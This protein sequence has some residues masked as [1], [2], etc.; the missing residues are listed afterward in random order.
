MFAYNIIYPSIS[1]KKINTVAFNSTGEWIAFGCARLGQ[2]LVWEWQ[3]ETCQLKQQVS[4]QLS[5]KCHRT[6]LPPLTAPN[7]VGINGINNCR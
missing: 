1:Q 5:L 7:S 4:L 6:L 2:L 3:S